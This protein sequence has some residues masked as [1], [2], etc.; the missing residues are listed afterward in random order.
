MRKTIPTKAGSQPSA[1]SHDPTAALDDII[2]KAS[3]LEI[4][5][6]HGETF[7]IR[8]LADLVAELATIV[9]K[10]DPQ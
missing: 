8:R 9:R 7:A 6:G 5:G 3:T 10:G 1:L 4:S 2:W